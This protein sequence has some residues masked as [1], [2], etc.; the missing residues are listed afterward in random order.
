MRTVKNTFILMIIGLTMVSMNVPLLGAKKGSVQYIA[1]HFGNPDF[2]Q[3]LD[4]SAYSGFSFYKSTDP[5]YHYSEEQKMMGKYTN[6]RGWYG[7]LPET[8]GFG[9]NSTPDSKHAAPYREGSLLIVDAAGT[10]YHQLPPSLNYNF[11][12]I[13][14]GIKKGSKNV[15]KGKLAK[16]LKPKKCK[17][18]KSTPVGE[19]QSVKGSKIDKKQD[20]LVGWELPD[21][22]LVDDQGNSVSLNDLVAGKSTVLVFYTM[23]AGHMKEADTKGNIVKEW[24]GEPLSALITGA[25]V[26]SAVMA[27]E[28]TNA[29]SF[30]LKTA[31]ASRVAGATNAQYNNAVRIL[32]LARDVK[33]SLKQ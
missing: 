27:T 31:K 3:A 26:E 9:P 14:A 12:D 19:L 10:I 11:S 16:P 21:Y 8:M 13:I 18:L 1:I 22:E 32:D 23:N 24:D 20:G 15:G 7:K 5:V 2:A 4:Q 30:L 28:P 29:A 17:V 25:E 33:K 6:L